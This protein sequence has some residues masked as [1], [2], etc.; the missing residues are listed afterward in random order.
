MLPTNTIPS[1][2]A[3]LPHE[4]SA[5]FYEWWNAYAAN[6]ENEQAFFGVCEI[7]RQALNLQPEYFEGVK[8]VTLDPSANAL[9]P[10]VTLHV[11][12]AMAQ[13][14]QQA[15]QARQ[16]PVTGHSAPA[17]APQTPHQPQAPVQMPQAPQMQPQNFGTA[18]PIATHGT[19]TQGHAGQVTQQMQPGAAPGVPQ[20]QT[21]AAPQMQ[22]VHVP[23]NQSKQFPGGAHTEMGLGNVQMEPGPQNESIPVSGIRGHAMGVTP[24]GG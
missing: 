15:Q 17:Q 2:Q 4:A 16:P 8:M 5:L 24:R 7:I 21:P 11:D 19:N 14:V 6:P 18:Q 9:T 23:A 10:T 12:A 20:V 13:Q 1:V 22:S 3:T